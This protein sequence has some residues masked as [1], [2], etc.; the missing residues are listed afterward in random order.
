MSTTGE[1]LIVQ[2]TQATLPAGTQPGSTVIAGF[3]VTI[4]QAD[5]PYT[6]PVA[7][8]FTQG[9]SSFAVYGDTVTINGDL[10]NP[11]MDVTICAR[12]I[13]IGAATLINTG[14]GVVTKGNYPA[15]TPAASGN[16]ADGVNGFAAGNITLAADLITVSGADTGAGT[17][18][19]LETL[20]QLLTVA[21]DKALQPGSAF[22]AALNQ[23][24]LGSPSL[25]AQL[26][27]QSSTL[28]LTNATLGSASL[29]G[30]TTQYSTSG[31]TPTLTAQIELSVALVAQSW[32]LNVFVFK[33]V[34]VAAQGT[35]TLSLSLEFTEGSPAPALVAGA[36]TA[37]CGTVAMSAQINEFLL[38][39]DSWALVVAYTPVLQQQ[40]A[41]LSTQLQAV[42]NT[43]AQ[44][45]VAALPAHQI[46]T[47]GLALLACGGNG[48]RGQDGATG[49]MGNNGSPGQN[50]SE[51]DAQVYITPPSAADG[52]SGAT[53]G[54]GGNGG[55]SGA[56]GAGGAVAVTVGTPPT[57]VG[58]VIAAG[59]GQ[60]GSPALAGAG[61]AGG[62]GGAA[63]SYWYL[64]PSPG[65]GLQDEKGNG[66]AGAQGAG[67]AAGNAGAWG[68]GG[69]NGTPTLNGAAPGNQWSAGSY[70]TIGALLP[71]CQL[72]LEQQGAQLAYLNAAAT[73][74]Y[75]DVTTYYNWLF[76][77][78][79]Q[80]LDN[81]GMP[82]QQTIGQ[83]AQLALSR[84]A[85]GHDY[86]GNLTN[87][88]PVLDFAAYSVQAA[89]LLNTATILNTQYTAA[90]AEGATAA[91]IAQATQNAI[92]QLQSDLQKY[93]SNAA[94]LDTQIKSQ[95]AAL[96]TLSSQVSQQIT[97][98]Q[99]AFTSDQQTFTASLFG[100]TCSF[101]NVMEGVGSLLEVGAGIMSL[102]K[103][104]GSAIQNIAKGAQGVFDDV[105]G[106]IS[107]VETAEADWTDLQT[108]WTNL[109]AAIA[110]GKNG[111]ILSDGKAF[112]ALLT[113]YFGQLQAAMTLEDDINILMTLIREQNQV[114]ASITSLWAQYLGQQQ[115][116]AQANAQIQR[117]S[118]QLQSATPPLSPDYMSFLQSSLYASLS[119]LIYNIYLMNQ[120]YCYWAAVSS[121]LTFPTI[122]LAG[123]ASVYAT[124]SGYVQEWQTSEGQPFSHFQ[125][126]DVVFT[127]A[128]NPPAFAL[129]QQT[130]Q[131]PLVIDLD[132][133]GPFQN[134]CNVMAETVSVTLQGVTLPQNET[135]YVT[136][137]QNGPDQCQ[138]QDGTVFTFSH[139][140][141]EVHYE[142]N[143]AKKEI[144]LTGTI[145]SPAQGFSGLSPFAGWLLDFT[146]AS[147]A[148]LTPQLGQLTGVT[149]TFGG[150]AL[151]LGAASVPA[152]T[153]ATTVTA[154]T[155]TAAEVAMPAAAVSAVPA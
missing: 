74:D 41:G 93:L 28:V 141:R 79:E 140:A 23:I 11:G 88:V 107:A 111:A 86:Y 44:E 108:A 76:S 26:N 38:A 72:G 62:T 144:T 110:A 48:G 102:Q 132:P 84:L 45:V 112:D 16:G 146:A 116:Y 95:Q 70:A 124:V 85:A 19:R 1:S 27:N 81:T 52:G 30:L 125:D 43:L 31:S 18:L 135:L 40:L 77:V 100:N 69:S 61:G 12:E 87:W 130:G 37:S 22:F 20:N 131:L 113:K 57:G 9:A 119:G 92:N 39:K 13:I 117:L 49:S 143:F 127:A 5:I 51:S 64:A 50:L 33:N 24:S 151:G 91:A 99:S 97:T 17:G 98:V 89:T 75:A 106:A 6:V 80:Y 47:G 65:G 63:G 55:S 103:N 46:G 155:A 136:L 150:Y 128:E 104:I 42:A 58:L 120:A 66:N 83:S 133:A 73:G 118:A 3:D 138:A 14:G 21:L 71:L 94:S 32:E 2:T 8:P 134:L 56:G 60:G 121:P 68:A 90:F 67:G 7:G 101:D 78:M 142:Y 114:R 96:A 149:L 147:N 145:G 126:I 34:P 35:F 154:S 10:V 59:G 25:Q 82:E 123:V 36:T 122:D 4:S 29:S 152:A 139:N 153:E 109:Q 148:W 137:T 54:T 105:K 53:G 15:G 129:V 115:L